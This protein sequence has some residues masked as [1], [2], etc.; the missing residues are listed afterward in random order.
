MTIRTILISLLLFIF[1]KANAQITIADMYLGY[2][3]QDKDSISR[4]DRFIIDITHEYLLEKP[5]NVEQK[6]YSFGLSF[7]KMFERPISKSFSIAIGPGIRS[8]HIYHNAEFKQFVDINQ[9]IYDTVAI[10]HPSVSYSINKTV[11]NYVDLAAEIR[12]KLGKENRFKIYFGFKGG[13]LFNQ[14]QKYSDGNVKYKRYNTNGFNKFSYG[15]TI[16]IGVGSVCLFANYLLAPV[17]ENNRSQKFQH[18]SIGFSF[19][20]F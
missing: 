2:A 4:Q 19:L 14:H 8:Q 17:Y 18:A 13:Y 10:F 6:F 20:L 16:R 5:K 15:P 9:N 7:S 1:V 12:L 11:L 3:L